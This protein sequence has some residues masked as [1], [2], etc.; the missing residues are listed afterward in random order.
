MYRV[1]TQDPDTNWDEVTLEYDDKRV[2]TP[3]NLI[4]GE[5]TSGV[6]V[7]GAMQTQ[8]VPHWLN[9]PKNSVIENISP[10]SEIEG[11]FD[12][13]SAPKDAHVLFQGGLSYQIY[14]GGNVP[15]IPLAQSIWFTTPSGAAIFNGGFTTW[16][17]DLSDACV[18]PSITATSE[19]ILQ[20]TTLTILKLWA[21]KD[22]G[23]QLDKGEASYIV[24]K[25]NP[26]LAKPIQENE[27]SEAAA[28]PLNIEKSVVRTPLA[29]T[30]SATH[31]ASH[32]PATKTPENHVPTQSQAP[33]D[34]NTAVATTTATSN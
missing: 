23:P 1:S 25:T 8:H 6:H 20:K 11:Y 21:Q 12:R 31:T 15:K 14:P 13:A 22:I 34:T 10:D 16:A 24:T 17:C 28:P 33:T 9:I 7:F 19:S 26:L 29:H 32:A 18:Y 30:P 27:K 3:S 2:N 5:L 4:T